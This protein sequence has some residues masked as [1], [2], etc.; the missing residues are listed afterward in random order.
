MAIPLMLT[1]CR[2]YVGI[3]M[4]LY[5]VSTVI[6]S[7]AIVIRRMAAIAIAFVIQTPY[8]YQ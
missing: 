1:K 7:D 3:Q 8:L 5:G 6:I 2:K 4:E